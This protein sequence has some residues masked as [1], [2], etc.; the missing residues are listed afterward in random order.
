M[1]D[2]VVVKLL[3]DGYF[4]LD[5]GAYF[6]VVPK[7][8]WSRKFQEIDNTVR[9]ATN[10]LYI[11]ESDGT[12]ILVDSG[13]GNKFDDK[14]RKIYRV[15]KQS[16]IYEYIRLHGDPNSVRMI[17][18]SHLHFDHVGHNADFKNAYAYAQADEFKAARY[19]NYITKA[20]YRLSASQIKN[21]VE[22]GGSKRINGFIRVIKT[23]GHTPGHQVIL[24]NA[25]GRKIMYFGD[26]VP[27]TFHLKLPYRTA[28]DLDP[29][30]TIEFKKN[31]VKMAIRE[32]YICIFNHDVETPAAIL[33]GDYSDPK[34]VK[35]DI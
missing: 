28:I 32:N 33:S 12:S 17:I 26:I 3:N 14:F 7:A 25:G 1:S 30:K 2:D 21:K 35:V 31:L 18:N 19:R 23:D 13:I 11:T 29:L 34:Y 10:V 5:A 20:N 27:S 9:L 15:E 22:I 24:I 4:S 8:I 6:G 16:D